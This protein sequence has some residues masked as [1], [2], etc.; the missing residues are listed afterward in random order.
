MDNTTS[1]P[2]PNPRTKPNRNNSV[3]LLSLHTNFCNYILRPLG[4]IRFSTSFPSRSLRPSIH[5]DYP[6]FIA[7]LPIFQFPILSLLKIHRL[8]VDETRRE[9]SWL[10]KFRPRCRTTYRLWN[11][12][13]PI[14]GKVGRIR[15]F[16][17]FFEKPSIKF[18]Q[19]GFL[20]CRVWNLF[21]NFSI[22]IYVFPIIRC[23][24]WKV[25]GESKFKDFLLY[26]HMCIGWKGYIDRKP[27]GDI[28]VAGLE[29]LRPVGIPNAFLNLL[30]RAKVESPKPRAY[31]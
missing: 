25:V 7:F 14:D 31:S 11:V 21:S 3:T 1:L 12:I 6:K 4:L 24:S 2:P 27:V 17:D 19:S 22:R 20:K 8:R 26:V 29:F 16:R 5:L 23:V 10:D 18:D 13:D 28:K 30:P 15:L 9:K